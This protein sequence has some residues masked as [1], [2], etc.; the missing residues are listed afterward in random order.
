V[1]DVAVTVEVIGLRGEKMNQNDAGLASSPIKFDVN[2]KLEE[3][4]RQSGR[5][6]VGFSLVVAT[7]PSVVKYELDGIAI[8]NGKD[9]LLGKM[10][11]TDPETKVP[12]LFQRVYQRIFTAIYLLGTLLDTV[13][14]P[15]GLLL[16]RP[17][18]IEQKPQVTNVPIGDEAKPQIHS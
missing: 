15:P 9:D 11:E 2:V 3:R 14:P 7:K 17:T 10:L 12:F 5:I 1:S 6:T 13:Y 4:E 16:G 8:L 18:Q